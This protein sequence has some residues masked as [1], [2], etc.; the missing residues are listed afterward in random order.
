MRGSET[1]GWLRAIIDGMQQDLMRY[2]NRSTYNYD[3]LVKKQQL[4]DDLTKILDRLAAI[5]NFDLWLRLNNEITEMK[6]KD[7][8]LKAVIIDIGPAPG[9]V[10]RGSLYLPATI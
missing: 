1:I 5:G 4:I 8:W 6:T 10:K 9:Y 7:P 2:R 3:L